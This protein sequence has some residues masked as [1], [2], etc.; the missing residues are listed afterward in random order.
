MWRVVIVPLLLGCGGATECRPSSVCPGATDAHHVETDTFGVF[1]CQCEPRANSGRG[2]VFYVLYVDRGPQWD[3]PT[4]QCDRLTSDW[5]KDSH[6]GDC[7]SWVA[8]P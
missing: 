8:P 4:N 6:D 1:V 2:V 3:A 7:A 5:L